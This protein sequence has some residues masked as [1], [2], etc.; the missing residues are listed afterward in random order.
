MT[1][2]QKQ[3]NLSAH[4]GACP[5]GTLIEGYPNHCP[6]GI[7]PVVTIFAA[8]FFLAVNHPSHGD[9]PRGDGAVSRNRARSYRPL[10]LRTYR[11]ARP[12]GAVFSTKRWFFCCSLFS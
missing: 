1:D 10:S 8:G 5:R 2:G 4:H 9:K 11:W 3:P 12:Y 7:N 6:T